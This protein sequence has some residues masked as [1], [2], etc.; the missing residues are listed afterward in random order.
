MTALS[1]DR[2]AQERS[3]DQYQDPIEAGVTCYVGALVVI[4]GAGNA[5][6][7]VTGTGLIARGVCEQFVDNSGGAAGIANVKTR[8]GLFKFKNDGS[9]DR[10]H[11]E[12]TAYIVD[13]QTVAATDGTGTRSEAGVIKQVEDNGVWVKIA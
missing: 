5:K 9:I 12:G 6:P 7:A 3:G 2:E 1:A 13:D 11:I 4:N 10:T 8:K